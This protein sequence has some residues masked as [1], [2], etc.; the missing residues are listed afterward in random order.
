[1]SKSLPTPPTL[2]MQLTS[3]L[4]PTQ[5]GKVDKTPH[6]FIRTTRS[7]TPKLLREVDTTRTTKVL[8]RKAQDRRKRDVKT[9]IKVTIRVGKTARIA[10]FSILRKAVL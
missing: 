2:K 6:K 3:A 9:K 8:A 5:R 4:G 1:M 7:T 10:I